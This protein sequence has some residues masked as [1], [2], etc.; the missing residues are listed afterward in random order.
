MVVAGIMSG[1][2]LDGIDVALVDVRGRSFAVKG[3]W[4]VPYPAKVR[5]AILSAASAAEI[6]RLHF[7]LG[8]LYAKAVEKGKV[9]PDLV[10]CH[11]QTIHHEGDP[12]PYLGHR[13]SSTLQ[14]GEAAVIAERLGVPVVSDF[15]PRDI[16]AGGRGAPLVPFVDYLLFRHRRRGRVA[17]NIGGIANITA[18]P[19]ACTPE[20]VIAFDTGPGNMVIDALASE[21]TRGKLQY[22]KGGRLAARGRIDEA[23][24]GELLSEPYYRRRP[25]KTAG[26]EQ[27]GREFVEK[28]LATK[29]P[30]PDLIATATA[31]TAASVALAIDRFVPMPVDELI[32]SGG[33]ARNPEIMKHLAAL[34]PGVAVATSSDFG[35]DADAKEAIAFALLG[36]ETWR[37]R[38]SNLPSA[39]GA[40][41]PVILGKI[42][43]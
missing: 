2:S 35:I 8:E 22:D 36:Y 28:L 24:L 4:T 32:V 33:G 40:R 19:P 27:Y 11:G 5:Q 25:P 38:P 7:L 17:L 10:A 20:Q 41:H 26:R 43:R 16:A 9:R 42:T 29:L 34:L 1:T 18:I 15:R 3:F 23:L 14:I 37:G 31:L 21:H 13:V 39:T 6:A 30:L 12:V